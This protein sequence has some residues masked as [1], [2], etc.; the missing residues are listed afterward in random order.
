MRLIGTVTT[1]EDPL[2]VRPEPS[3]GKPP[4]GQLAREQVVAVEKQIGEWYRI[5]SC[6]L[7]GYVHGAYLRVAEHHAILMPD[8]YHR[9]AG[10]RPDWAPSACDPRYHGAII[11]ATEGAHYPYVDWFYSQWPL[12]QR[13]GDVEYGRTWFRGCYHYLRFDQDPAQQAEHFVSTVRAAGGL[14]G[15]DLPPV[16]DVELGREGGPNHDASAAQVIDTTCRW[17]EVVRNALGR[18]VMLYGRNAMRELNIKDRMGCD[19][20]WAPRYNS[21]LEDHKF[22]LEDIG[23]SRDQLKFWQYTDGEHN[24]TEYPASVPGIGPSDG[25]AFE[26]GTL[27]DMRAFLVDSWL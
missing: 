13:T 14:G 15:L 20:L 18:K 19:Y 21:V 9:S 10:G 11:K 8:L 22:A 7:Q 2:N 26:G 16:V 23:W 24:F 1:V 4:I 17:V 27:E 3:T 5:R 6:K 25:N 12:L